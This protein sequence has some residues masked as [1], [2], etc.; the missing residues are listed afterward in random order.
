MMNHI[1]VS[2]ILVLTT[3]AACGSKEKKASP[4][5]APNP[6]QTSQGAPTVPGQ[7][8]YT[9]PPVNGYPNQSIPGSTTV[10]GSPTTNPYYPGSTGKD[11][12]PMP[13]P[14]G[15]QGYI[16]NPGQ[17]C[18]N[19]YYCNT[20]NSGI[21]TG[22]TFGS[23]Y[24]QDDVVACM[25]QAIA[26]GIP[27]NGAWPI[28]DGGLQGGAFG[29]GGNLGYTISGN[30]IGMQF[31]HV[32]MLNVLNVLNVGTVQLNNPFAVYCVKQK[33]VLSSMSYNA[34]NPASVIVYSNQGW[35]GVNAQAIP[36]C[37]MY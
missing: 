17:A 11:G 23:F 18:P 16:P 33:S 4:A 6:S 36:N 22:G 27:V 20:P 30:N 5:P 8:Y 19:G 21:L 3:I 10:K 25:G 7:P 35:M 37:G 34:C 2:F 13:Y 12:L 29:Y 32:V 31:P 1:T 15:N 28:F 14:Q 26:R 24:T 9:P